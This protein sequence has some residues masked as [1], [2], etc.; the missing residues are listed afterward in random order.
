MTDIAPA[1]R[2]YHGASSTQ[3]KDSVDA[4]VNP[5]QAE[6][7]ANKPE[8]KDNEQRRETFQTRLAAF[9]RQARG[10]AARA[11]SA[12]GG[13]SS[14]NRSLE[15]GAGPS[16]RAFRRDTS[17]LAPAPAPLRAF[18]DPAT[19]RDQDHDL[20]ADLH[21]LTLEQREARRPTTRR[22]TLLPGWFTR[23][24]HNATIQRT[25][26]Y[27]RETNADAVYAGV[28]I[29]NLYVCSVTRTAPSTAP[30]DIWP[31]VH[32]MEQGTG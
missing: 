3:N 18:D 26:D 11:G 5:A 31:V 4:V 32:G 20:K 25:I 28:D 8:D 15:E 14:A 22:D 6:I 24:D 1:I 23:H 29:S 9:A 7:E 16:P 30:R 27:V 10:I 17:Q 13:E 12:R 2:L 19:L 21:G